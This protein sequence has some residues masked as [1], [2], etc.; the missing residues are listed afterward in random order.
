MTNDE[1]KS[2][3]NAIWLCANHSIQIDRDVELHPTILLVGWKQRAEERAIAEQGKKLPAASDATDLLVTA[4][5]GKAATF[6]TSAIANVH[7]ASAET[8]QKLDPRFRVDTEYKNG[9]ATIGLHAQEAVPFSFKIPSEHAA[10]W[11]DEIRRLVEH[12]SPAQVPVSGLEVVGV[13]IL[14]S[15]LRDL[16][17]AGSTLSFRPNG[18]RATAKLTL[19]DPLTSAMEQFDDTPGL[20]FSGGKSARFEGTNC[21]AIVRLQIVVNFDGQSS[22]LDMTLHFDLSLWNQVEVLRLPYFDKVV[23]LS[24]AIGSGSEISVALEVDGRLAL[25]GNA[26]FP[27]DVRSG[28]S[29]VAMSLA[30]L[31]AARALSE[32]VGV[33]ILVNSKSRITE[34]EH[35]RLSEIVSILEGKQVY[36]ASQLE[37]DPT[38]VLIVGSGSANIHHLLETTSF[39]TFSC[40]Y[41]EQH[42]KVF[43]TDIL[44]KGA[45]LELICVKPSI[46]VDPSSLQEGDSVLVT[47]ERGPEF[48]CTYRFSESAIHE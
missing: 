19:L 4:L 43:D 44:L 5:T 42:V 39:Q 25:S 14:E 3:S 23:K 45:E 30:Y 38:S 33:P 9:I 17:G 36:D 37:S 40:R 29:D 28:Q 2:I 46:T 24:K 48:R 12:G 41:G 34:A 20:V 7:A 18:V 26:K 35:I 13:P 8:L 10:R 16:S 11:Q 6:L 47:W 1:R 32:L 22:E 27:P 21:A 31:A 15:V